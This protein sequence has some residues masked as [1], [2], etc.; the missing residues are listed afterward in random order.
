[1]GDLDTTPTGVTQ[2]AGQPQ[3]AGHAAAGAAAELRGGKP[4]VRGPAVGGIRGADALTGTG[5][6]V[7]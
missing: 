7:G 2:R 4:A 6:G 1:M 3:L 5:P